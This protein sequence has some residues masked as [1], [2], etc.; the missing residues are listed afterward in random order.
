MTAL[1]ILGLAV[2]LVILAG[3]IDLVR[4]RRLRE[5]Y[6]A[7]WLIVAVGQSILALFPALLDRTASVVGIADPPNLLAFGAVIFLL[8]VTAHLSLESSKL[9][10]ETRILA[11]EVA[12]LREQVES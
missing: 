8:G 11:E 5:K 10:E 6:A 4:R 9:E 3:A 1:Q 7:L 12:M 2:S